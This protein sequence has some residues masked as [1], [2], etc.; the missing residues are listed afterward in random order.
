MEKL[1][2]GVSVICCE[3]D[4]TM[5]LEFVS[6]GLAA[7][8]HMTVEEVKELYEHDL[9]QGYIRMTGR[10]TW[11]HLESIWKKGRGIVN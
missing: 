1:P 7:M 4:G 3:K 6:D 2:G 9:L 11:K 5:R 10:E 8:T